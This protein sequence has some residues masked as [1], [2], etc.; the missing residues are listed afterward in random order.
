MK[1]T[2]LAG[3]IFNHKDSKKG[4]HDTYRAALDAQTGSH[5]VFAD[6]SNTRFAS[7]GDG[8]GQLMRHLE[9]HI[10][11]LED[12]AYS[13]TKVG[14]THMEANLLK[15]LKDVPTQQELMAMAIFTE[16]VYH[17]YLEHARAGDKGLATNMLDEA[18][19]HQHLK[20]F[21]ASVIR[22]PDV[23]LG[24]SATYET[25]TL[26]GRRFHDPNIMGSIFQRASTALHLRACLVAFFK[27][28][29]EKL[30][31]FTTEF[32]SGNIDK[33]TDAERKLSFRPH[34][35]DIN[36]GMLGLYRT[37]DRENP[38]GSLAI[39]NSIQMNNLNETEQW[40]KTHLGE[41]DDAAL[42]KAARNL[43]KQHLEKKRRCAINQARVERIAQQKK[44]ENERT[45]RLA[46]KERQIALIQREYDPTWLHQKSTTLVL[47]NDQVKAW[48]AI[49]P[50][51]K[52]PSRA[53]KAQKIA[54]LEESIHRWR[55]T[56]T[57]LSSSR[58]SSL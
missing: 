42:M 44:A 35:N 32:T 45:A 21:L 9:W 19:W 30:P 1:A 36:E 43:D 57:A 38:R 7:H 11:Y 49:D 31:S 33:L 4:H 20:E 39:Y 27:G 3:G 37:Y 18:P 10:Q 12:H 22:D 53:T 48:K 52:V 14:L 28:A 55:E 8:A 29:L 40:R 41:S 23:I 16:C 46:E 51:L 13:K 25:A 34:T 5:T 54:L 15:A 58:N 2:A 50:T 24:E 6:V 26:D 47:I 56:H 17:P